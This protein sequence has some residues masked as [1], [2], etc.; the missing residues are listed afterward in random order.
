M[1]LEL[2]LESSGLPR[3]ER[4][5]RTQRSPGSVLRN[6]VQ[7]A[8]LVSR[9]PPA[10]RLAAQTKE[11]GQLCFGEAQFASAQSTQAKCFQNGVRELTCVGEFNC[12]DATPFLLGMTPI[13]LDPPIHRYST[14]PTFPGPY[15]GDGHSCRGDNAQV[16]RA[17][18]AACADND[19]VVGAL[20]WG[21]E[22]DARSLAEGDAI[23]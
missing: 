1:V 7:A 22:N 2:G 11:I 18:F 9:P 21:I 6:C 17:C 10:D 13:I 23:A 16:K 3:I 15:L 5:P 20:V 14:P 8:L 4:S 19:D 12:H